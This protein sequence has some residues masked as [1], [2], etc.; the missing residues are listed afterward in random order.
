[1]NDTRELMHWHAGNGKTLRELERHLGKDGN[2]EKNCGE[3]LRLALERHYRWAN[4]LPE[5]LKRLTSWRD[6]AGPQ[7]LPLS[8]V[9]L[10]QKLTKVC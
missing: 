4:D 9:P 6:E 3:G 7:L 8:L 2:F 1:M 5:E 10:L